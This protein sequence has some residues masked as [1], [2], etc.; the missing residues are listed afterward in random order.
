M[1]KVY[2]K[3]VRDKIPVILEL[4]GIK[5]KYH[6]LSIEEYREAL[7]TKLV[8]EA[9]ELLKAP[10]K[11]E[12]IEELA[13]IREVIGWICKCEDISEGDMLRRQHRKYI[14]KGGFLGRI[15]LESVEED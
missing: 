14:Q 8:E 7:K 5:A 3:L 6:K 1:E 11:D 15:F 10:T 2:N 9:N 12:M 13:D 4:K